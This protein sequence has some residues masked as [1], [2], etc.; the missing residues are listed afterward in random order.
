[1]T[2]RADF[3]QERQIAE[4]NFLED[5]D[6]QKWKFKFISEK[7]EKLIFKILLLIN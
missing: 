2:M 6:R 3:F 1:M 5:F 4:T 7:N